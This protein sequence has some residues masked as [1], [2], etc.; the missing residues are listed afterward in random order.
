MKTYTFHVHG[1]HC[2]ACVV[3][4]ET[5]LKDHALVESAA[6]DLKTCCVEVQG[7]FGE[8]EAEDVAAELSK[9]ME[10]HGYKLS[11]VKEQKGVQWSDFKIALPVALGFMALFVILQKLGLVN[12]ISSGNVSYG[13]AF[14]IGAIASV[15]TCMAVVGSLVLS[16]SANFAKEGDAVKPQILFHIGRLVSFFI[17]GGLIG[18][19]GSAFQLGATGTFVMSFVVAFVMLILGIN[20]LDVFPW[21]KKLQPTLPKFISNHLLEVKKLNHTLTPVLLGVLTF[22]L[23]CGFTQSMQIYSLTTGSFW[24][25]ATTMFVFALGTLPVL[26]LLSFSSLGIQN[27]AKSGVFF[28]TAGL[29]VI[30]FALFNLI[31]SLVIIGLIPPMFNF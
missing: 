4:T 20:L 1:M 25:G 11:T 18:T 7:N 9:V 22:F 29:V 6:A 16:V 2:N 3:L 8:R 24:G 17:L 28:K 13:T 31:N 27:K 23:P 26:A 14:L 30:F 19:L 15:S 5:E 12:L 21:A 10:P